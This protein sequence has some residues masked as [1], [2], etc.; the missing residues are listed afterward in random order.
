MK[1]LTAAQRRFY[2]NITLIAALRLI[3]SRLL[4][5][6]S[7][8]N[9]LSELADTTSGG[10]PDRNV[11]EYYGGSIP[12]I[13]SG[14]L[15]DGLIAE[16]EEFITE[17]GLKNS[18]AKIYQKGTL[19]VALYGATVGKTGILTIDAASNQAVCA[20]RPKTEE[21]STRFL[22]WFFRYK[23]PEFLNNSFGGAQP[24]ISQRVLRETKLPLPTSELQSS[25]CEF[26]EAVEKRQSRVENIDL[27]NLPSE[28]SEVR[29]TVGR[30]EELA[31]RIEEARELRRRAI[32]ESEA[33]LS[34]TSKYFFGEDC[35]KFQKGNLKEF[36][37]RITKGESPEWQGFTYQDSGPLFVRSENVL[38]GELDLSKQVHIPAEFHQKLSR[39]QLHPGDVLINLVGASIGRSCVVPEDIGEANVNQAVAVIS[40]DPARL[41]SD[42]LM[43]F[44]I[45]APAQ[46]IIQGGKV[47]TARPNISLGDLRKLALPVPP[48]EEQR[49]IIAYLDGLETK[50]NALKRHQ[51]ETAAELDALMPS[52]L[53]RAFRG[54][55]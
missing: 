42:Y 17:E 54:E 35:T 41:V 49:R 23:R 15:N 44:L 8:L 40:P 46:D 37:K 38:W 32:E 6:G 24:N 1:R 43:H 21:L 11:G 39:S 34:A 51:A 3:F 50:I 7:P 2:E 33:L 14:E 12:W 28:L 31:A 18:S 36:T 29:R 53:D 19:V 55:L 22:Y 20:I 27:P 13:K 52:I 26:L 25:I 48:L 5:C 47:E 9:S 45:S 16:A 30:I 10:T 4:E